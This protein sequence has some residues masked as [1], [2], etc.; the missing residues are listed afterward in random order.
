M[1]YVNNYTNSIM[2]N[3]T[4]LKSIFFFTLPFSFPH[5]PSLSP[6]FPRPVTS[7]L[8]LSRKGQLSPLTLMPPPLFSA[9]HFKQQHT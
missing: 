3:L 2:K 1:R 9:Q 8:V 5:L 6:I 7:F 4:D